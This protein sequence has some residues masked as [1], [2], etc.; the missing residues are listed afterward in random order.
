MFFRAGSGTLPAASE[1]GKRSFQGLWS[2]CRMSCCFPGLRLPQG[3]IGLENTSCQD[4]STWNCLLIWGRLCPLAELEQRHVWVYFLLQGLLGREEWQIFP[5]EV[6]VLSKSRSL[7]PVL[8]ILTLECSPRGWVWCLGGLERYQIA[9]SILGV[10]LDLL[11]KYSR[12]KGLENLPCLLW[13]IPGKNTKKSHSGCAQGRVES[14]ISSNL[15]LMCCGI[16]LPPKME[17]CGL[18]SR[19]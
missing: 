11:H 7:L 16:C 17:F 5:P 18:R 19:S 9:A 3:T 10:N 4:R 6:C 15:L 13:H 1:H 14:G 2:L 8:W 12:N